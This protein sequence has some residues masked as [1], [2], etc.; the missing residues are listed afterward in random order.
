MRKAIAAAILAGGFSWSAVAA[1]NVVRVGVLNDM[2]SVYADFQ[3]PGSVLAAKLAAEDYMKGGEYKVE[4]ISADH[5]NKPDIGANTAR[6]WLDVDGVHVIVDLPNSAVAFAVNEIVRDKNKVMIGSGAGS[7]MLTGERCSPNM[8]HWTYDTW[9]YGHSAARAAFAGGGKKWFFIT[10]DYAF[11][12]D[13]EKQASDEIK[14]LGGEV[15]GAVRHP[16]NA[17]DFSSFLLQ[18]QSSGADVVAFANAGGDLTN[19]LKQAAE[20]GLAQKQKVIGLIFGVTNV[21]ALGL[22][23]TQ[24]LQSVAPFYWD[25]NDGTRAWSRRFQAA[26]PKKMMPNDMHAGVYA[27]LMHYFR[28]VE[29]AGGPQDGR[30]IVEAMK[31]MPTD[32]PL[33]GKGSIRIDG[34]KMHPMYL[35]EAKKPSESKGDWD[36]LK[37]VATVPAEQAFRPLKDGNCPLVK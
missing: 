5:Q 3:G 36:Y 19:S 26:H 29:K 8:V 7:A 10:A 1:D 34:R 28:A 24:G 18:A 27:G 15:V 22:E 21:P 25:M 20:F 31:A 11:G 6:Q 9:S 35:L 37:V 13:L 23:A 16:I 4:V 2:S 32:D 12:H 33:F 30:A 14:A 17:S